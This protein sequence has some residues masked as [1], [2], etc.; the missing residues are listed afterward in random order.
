MLLAMILTYQTYA[1][2]KIGITENFT[3]SPNFGLPVM[4]YMQAQSTVF[5]LLTVLPKFRMSVKQ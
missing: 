5:K 1:K 2:V 4:V 3:L